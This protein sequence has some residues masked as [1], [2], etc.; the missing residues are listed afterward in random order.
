MQKLE[1]KKK[2]YLMLSVMFSIF[3]PI[4]VVATIFGA[5]GNVFLLVIGIILAG[6]GFYGATLM[7]SFYPTL[8]DKIKIIR[9]IESGILDLSVIA[10]NL[11][12]KV[13]KLIPMITSI[14]NVYVFGYSFNKDR[15]SL[16]L[17]EKI[18]EDVNGLK[19]KYCGATISKLDHHCSN[20]GAIIKN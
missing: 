17:N 14:L 3:L 1:K 16:I 10:S 18:I 15:T 7:W 11:N 13:R 12:I 6:S 4:G 8:L 9:Q 19:C 2:I 20:C 5:L